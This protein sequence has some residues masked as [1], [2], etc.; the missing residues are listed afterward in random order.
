M[1]IVRL[2]MYEGR[3]LDK[4]RRLVEGLTAVVVEVCDVQPADVHVVI[5]EVARDNWGIGGVVGSDRQR[6]R[7][8]AASGDG[9]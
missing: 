8:R 1:P 7:E 4:K 5:E 2:S 6:S 9:A 3:D